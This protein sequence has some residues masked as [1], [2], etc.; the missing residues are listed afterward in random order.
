MDFDGIFGNLE[1][2]LCLLIPDN[3]NRIKIFNNFYKIIMSMCIQTKQ[4]LPIVFGTS[5]CGAEQGKGR[6]R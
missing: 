6:K 4:A 3:K 2:I 1:K 5:F